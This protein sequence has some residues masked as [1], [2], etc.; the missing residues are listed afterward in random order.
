M[1]KKLISTLLCL[2]MVF[3]LLPTSAMAAPTKLKSFELE[4][5]LPKGGDAF[6]LNYIPTIKS[7]K[8]G[9]IDLLATGAYIQYTYWNGEFDYDESNVPV[10]R[11][12]GTYQVTIQLGLNTA[13]GYCANYKMSS[14]GQYLVG[15]DTI[16]ATVNGTAA[17]VSRNKPPYFP[18]MQLNLKLAGDVFTVE[19]KAER[20][21]EWEQLQQTRRAMYTPRTWAESVAC[22]PDK[23]PEKVVVVNTDGTDLNY[24]FTNMT[25]LVMDVS[26]AEQITDYI[27]SKP[28]LKEIWLSPATDPCKFV[29][30]VAA[31]QYNRIKGMYTYEYRSDIPM[32][33]AA[34]TLFIPESRASEFLGKIGSV[35]TAFTIR[36]YSGSNVVAAQKAGASATKS[37]CATHKY[38]NQI[39]SADRVYTFDD[40]CQHARLYYY[41][42]AY[43]GKCENNPKHVDYNHALGADLLAAIKS[44]QAGV[45]HGGYESGHSRYGIEQPNDSAYIGV[46]AAGQH[47]WWTSCAICGK[48]F[49]NEY[50]NPNTYDQKNEGATNRSFAEYKAQKAA[51]LKQLEAQALASTELYPDTFTLPLKSDA[52]MNTWAQAD[53]N[54]ALN[55]DLLDTALLGSD[56]TR[57]ISRLQFC[58][59]AVRLAETLTGKEITP[60]ASGKFTDTD[61]AYAR[62]AYAAG[63]TTGVTDTTFNPNG[64]L[65]RQQMATFIYRALQYVAAHS[66]YKYTAYESKLSSYTD[67]G[68][69]HSWAV[70]PMA[71]MNALDLVKGT[72]S[73]TINPNGT[74]TIQQAIVVAERSVYAHQIGWYQVQP[75]KTSS[76]GGAPYAEFDYNASLREGD[77]VWVT[78]RRYG[79]YNSFSEMQYNLPYVYAPIINPFNGQAAEIKNG[80]LIP[81]RG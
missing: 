58:S 26:N 79:V 52:K 5:E 18:E 70:E 36:T 74:C 6:D 38:T 32:Y 2:I 22:D 29:G 28:C 21:A 35:N 49:S 1:K 23:L 17:T 68:L 45:S 76:T 27:S 40:G 44:A 54:L 75:R 80:D 72:S 41:S 59:V 10:F 66:D 42:C 77:Y 67:A 13:A 20:S 43:C 60:V 53:V 25:T 51:T 15:P 55:D 57:S 65:T 4:I 34:S 19:Q 30:A 73:T 39:C 78:G 64:T 63:I 14:D 50:L 47:V 12:G 3:T 69:L 24:D 31:S 9:S 62:K 37:L 56:Y 7:L 46:N 11:N 16:S 71:F 81:I 61:N 8:S 33:T 48:A